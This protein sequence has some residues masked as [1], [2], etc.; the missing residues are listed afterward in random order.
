MSSLY[1]QVRLFVQSPWPLA[2]TSIQ[3]SKWSHHSIR[4]LDETIANIVIANYHLALSPVCPHMIA[5]HG[6]AI[7]QSRNSFEDMRDLV[8]EARIIRGKV[9]PRVSRRRSR[10]KSHFRGPNLGFLWPMSFWGTK[11]PPCPTL[12][13]IGPNG[14][15]LGKF[16]CLWCNQV[17]V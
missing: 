17:A 1:D 16:W 15:N 9:T 4:W 10:L 12:V 3:A 7:A 6:R 5:P 2:V 8:T 13:Q 11:M 14:V